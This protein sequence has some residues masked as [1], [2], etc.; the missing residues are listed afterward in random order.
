VTTA[1]NMP[2]ILD[3]TDVPPLDGAL[4]LP[5][6]GLIR[7]QGADAAKFLH[8]Q[9]T[10]DIALLG[11]SEARLAAFCSPKGRMLASFIGF[12]LADD[13]LLLACHRDLLPATLKRLSMFVMRAQCKLTDASAECDLHGVA[14]PSAEQLA[15]AAG[16]G[17]ATW[18]KASLPGDAGTC[19]RL[20]AAGNPGAQAVQRL[21]VCV[22]AGAQLPL[23]MPP[24]PPA[25]WDWL[26]VQSGVAMVG[27]ALTEAFV[28]QMLNYESVGG[29]NFKKGCYPGQEVVARSQF[30]GTLK[31][32]TF[33]VAASMPVAAPL[34]VGQEVF[35]SSDAEQACGTVVATAEW[36]G[37]VQALVSMPTAASDGGQLT[38]QSPQGPAL[39]VLTLPYA[40]LADV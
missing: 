12:K 37:Q 19:V 1:T 2:P 6:W 18:A 23:A 14:G 30:R 5:Q 10:Q 3:T 9:L 27:Q 4:P 15:L 8:G 39:T 36:A 26:E 34:T 25:A 24:L 11:L 16:L 22:P 38:A 35:H 28:P 21:L 29:V 7:A 40:L 17:R 20:P 31:R 33:R 32:R 13:H